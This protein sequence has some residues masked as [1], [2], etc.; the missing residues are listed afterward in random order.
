[1]DICVPQMSRDYDCLSVSEVCLS[2][3]TDYLSHGKNIL[4]T[5]CQY[6]RHNCPS[7]QKLTTLQ[8]DSKVGSF[9]SCQ[10]WNL[11]V[12][13]WVTNKQ[14]TMS[15]E[16]LW[17]EDNPRLRPAKSASLLPSELEWL[18]CRAFEQWNSNLIPIKKIVLE[19]IDYLCVANNTS[20]KRT[21]ERRSYNQS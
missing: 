8:E 13:R 1:M 20:S 18:I 14:T 11:F 9:L 21:A 15:L 6:L 10:L 19:N 7:H 3:T 2:R 12:M 5:A 4:M 17:T 16:K